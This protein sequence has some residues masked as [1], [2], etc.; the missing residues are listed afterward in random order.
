MSDQYPQYQP[1]E[2]QGPRPSGE[3]EPTQRFDPTQGQPAPG[4]QPPAPPQGAWAPDP[5]YRY[6]EQQPGQTPYGAGYAGP[7]PQQTP[8]GQQDLASSASGFFSALFDFNF[9]TF[10]TPKII[11]AVYVVLTVLIGLMAVAVLLAALV[12]GQVGTII[13]ALIGVPLVGIVYL[14]LARMTLELYFAVVRLSEDVHERLP[15]Q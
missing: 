1:P 4:Q 12:S 11:K 6:Q 9:D 15:R 5:G 8:A 2:G 3:P 13:A 14:A 10:I 7:P